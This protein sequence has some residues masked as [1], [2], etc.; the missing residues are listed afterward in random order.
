VGKSYNSY[1]ITQRFKNKYT[2]YRYFMMES[3]S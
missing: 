3:Q 2:T 1:C